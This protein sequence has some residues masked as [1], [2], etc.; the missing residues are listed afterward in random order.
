M[1]VD[2][3]RIDAAPSRWGYR[4]KRYPHRE[5]AAHSIGGVCS[6]G[7]PGYVPDVL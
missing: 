7:G 1:L 5:G 2:G 6:F 3:L 4:D